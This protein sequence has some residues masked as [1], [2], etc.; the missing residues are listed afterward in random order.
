MWAMMLK[1]RINCGSVMAAS[2]FLLAGH[3]PEKDSRSRRRWIGRGGRPKWP[4]GQTW[5]ASWW[6]RGGGRRQAG[7]PGS[8]T[9]AGKWTTG[10]LDSLRW[11]ARRWVTTEGGDPAPSVQPP[12]NNEQPDASVA[13]MTCRHSVAIREARLSL[14]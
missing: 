6:R 2:L 13:G 11:H 4:T 9:G 8:V 14:E 3:H 12:S 1:L 7:G 5:L 10:Q